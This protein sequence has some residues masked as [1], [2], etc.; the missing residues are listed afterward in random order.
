VTRLVVDL[1]SL[2]ELI[3][4]MEQ[5]LAQ[6][7][8]LRDEARRVERLHPTWTGDAASAQAHAQARWAA[9]AAEVQD[10]LASLQALAGAAHANYVAAVAANRRMWAL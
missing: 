3:D 10:S 9:A 4:R 5:Y 1:T 8:A 2:A 6:L 7:T